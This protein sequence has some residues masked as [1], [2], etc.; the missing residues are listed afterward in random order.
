VDEKDWRELLRMLAG[1]GLQIVSTDR[2]T[3]TVCV[4]VPE[5]RQTRDDVIREWS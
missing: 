2:G 3:L 1:L 5:I 4:R